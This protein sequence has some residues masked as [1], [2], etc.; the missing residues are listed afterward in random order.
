MQDDLVIKFTTHSQMQIDKDQ[1]VTFG[2]TFSKI[3]SFCGEDNVLNPG[4]SF[5]VFLINQ[6]NQEQNYD[7]SKPIGQVFVRSEFT[8]NSKP[9][10]NSDDY[11]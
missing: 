10:I 2:F 5:P 6:K 9:E 8:P 4:V 3:S 1:T 11:T 7:S